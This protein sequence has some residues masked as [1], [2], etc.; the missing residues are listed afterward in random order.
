MLFMYIEVLLGANEFSKTLLIK[1][2]WDAHT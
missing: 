1:I 2:A